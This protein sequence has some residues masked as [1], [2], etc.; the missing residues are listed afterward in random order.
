MPGGCDEAGGAE[1]DDQ[2]AQAE[3]LRPG[4]RHRGWSERDGVV[5]APPCER[6]HEPLP[7]KRVDD[8]EERALARG[9]C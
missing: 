2:L 7:A 5:V 1:A 4:S 8:G 9:R 3:S 6:L